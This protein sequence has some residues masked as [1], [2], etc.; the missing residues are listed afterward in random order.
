MQQ[1]EEAV[2]LQ[3]RQIR[4]PSLQQSSIG[5]LQHP[6]ETHQQSPTALSRQGTGLAPRLERTNIQYNSLYTDFIITP[7]HCL[8]LKQ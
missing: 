6:K 3:D 2:D 1:I 7:E 5:I 8:H 4:H